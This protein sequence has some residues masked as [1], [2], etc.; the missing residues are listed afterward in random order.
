MLFCTL[1]TIL[2]NKEINKTDKEIKNAKL[3]FL[4]VKHK[5]TKHK[6][7]EKK[8]RKKK[9]SSDNGYESSSESEGDTTS[10]DSERMDRWVTQ[11]VWTG[12]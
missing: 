8:H 7:K 10:S 1:K 6:K 4:Q 12:G 9:R 2:K 5:K 3:F 11:N